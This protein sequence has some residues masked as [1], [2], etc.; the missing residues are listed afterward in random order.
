MKVFVRL[1]LL[2]F[3]FVLHG[4]P[5]PEIPNALESFQPYIGDWYSVRDSIVQRQ[6]PDVKEMIGF[7]FEWDSP[8]KKVLR[9]YE[10]IPDGDEDKTILSNIVVQNPRTGDL[11][12]LGYQMLNDFLFKGTFHFL[13]DN[14]GFVRLYDVHYPSHTKFR[15]PKDSLKGT[16]TYRDVCHLIGRDTLDCKVERWKDGFWIPWG[17]GR[18]FQMHRKTVKPEIANVY[19]EVVWL[20]GEWKSSFGEAG[21]TMRFWWG[22][23]ERYVYYENGFAKK[24]GEPQKLESAGIITYHGIRDQVVFMNTYLRKNTH[25][26]SEGWYEFKDDGSIHRHFTCHYKEGDGLPWSDGTKAPTG[27]KSIDFKQI[28]TPI[29]EDSFSGEFYWKKNGIWENPIKGHRDRKEIWR[30]VR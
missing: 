25:L 24:E 11:E 9:Y 1:Y 14:K 23:N 29:D 5:S 19:K 16:I 28:W 27:G 13:E 2:F 10:G 8:N 26:I 3:P 20:I 30:R 12:F 4:Q 6:F 15:H 18:P 17:S 21:A 22:E 7:R